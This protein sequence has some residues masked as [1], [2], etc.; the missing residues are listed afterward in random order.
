MIILTQLWNFLSN[1]PKVALM[2]MCHEELRNHVCVMCMRKA[3]RAITKLVQGRIDQF[4]VAN[5]DFTDSRLPTGICSTCRKALQKLSEGK[6]GQQLPDVFDY[7]SVVI[8][9]ERRSSSTCDCLLCSIATSRQG[10]DHP[11]SLGDRNKGRRQDNV[12]GGGDSAF[13]KKQPTPVKICPACLTTCQV[14][15][16]HVCKISTRRENLLRLAEAD[17]Q[18]AAMI[19]SAVIKDAPSSP[20]GTVRLTQRL[21]GRPVPIKR[22]AVHTSLKVA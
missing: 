16:P 13:P 2:S 15:H 5:L 18:G 21:G 20:G 19:A 11:L 6:Y 14:G 4:F 8:S 17:P 9:Q 3:D 22:G 10:W 7:S 12:N 1:M